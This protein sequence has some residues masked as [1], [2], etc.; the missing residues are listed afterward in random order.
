MNHKEEDSSEWQPVPPGFLERALSSKNR[1]AYESSVI[2]EYARLLLL[3]FVAPLVIWFVYSIIKYQTGVLSLVAALVLL[4]SL[5]SS[6]GYRLL[7]IALLVAMIANVF[8]LVINPNE[9]IG[10]TNESPSDAP[11]Y[12]LLLCLII[13]S[14]FEIGAWVKSSSRTTLIK[15]LAWGVLAIPAIIYILGIPLFNLLWETFQGDEKKLTIRDPNWSFL[16]EAAFQAAKFGIF[17]VFAYLAACLGS[18]LNVVAYCIPRGESVGLRDSKCPHCNTKISRI[19]NFPIFSY[20]NLGARCRA[21]QE[22]I[23][24]RYLI[25]ELVVAA[26]FG[27]LFLY[28]LITGCANVPLMNIH[29]QGVLWIILYPKWPA[30]AIYFFHAFLMCAVLVLS[31]FESDKQPLKLPFAIIV[32]LGFFVWAAI[33]FPIQPIPVFEHLPGISLE[34][35]PWIG[36]LLKLMVGG[37][38]GAIVGR[39]AGTIFSA[40]HPSILTFAFMLT[41]IV[42]GWQ[43]L[44]QVIVV[45]GIMVAIV[46]FFPKATN[47]LYC[48]PTTILFVAIVI[49]HPFWKTIADWWRFN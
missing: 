41:G 40:S 16:N 31:L 39:V 47:L 2:G 30:I 43:A 49:H 38:V 48:R 1:S 4:A 37:I 35:S 44:A 34:F 26:I 22:S 19:D 32:G 10:I 25:I 27:S 8:A 6:R 45:F 29:H 36:Q 14:L 17:A 33:Y 42:L 9:S 11:S 12:V 46:R 3:L 13:A 28:E 7:R 21:C 5:I 18:F 24:I 23:S 20:I 15:T